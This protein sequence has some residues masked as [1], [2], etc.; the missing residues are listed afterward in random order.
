[1]TNTNQFRGQNLS[2][3]DFTQIDLSDEVLAH[4]T[5]TNCKFGKCVGTNFG[6]C[7]GE[8]IDFSRSDLTGSTFN[9]ADQSVI[10]CL[11]GAVW[12]GV[13]INR[14]S[15]WL[16]TQNPWWTFATNAFV[17]IGCLV[18]PLPEWQRIC[19]TPESVQ[20]L[21]TLDPFMK[22]RCDE[23][24]AWWSQNKSLIESWYDSS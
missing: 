13:T 8:K 9:K 11:F 21:A 12:N 7:H 4:S 6:S 3:I 10:D 24:F 5:L 14:V 16:I 15:P 23:A 2:G 17:S 20:E 18:M 19:R 22:G 1:M